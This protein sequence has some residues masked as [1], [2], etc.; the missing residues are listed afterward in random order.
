MSQVCE[1]CQKRPRVGQT[2]SH[3]NI[4]T[5]RWQKINLQTKRIQGKKVL[6]CSRCL[7]ALE[8]KK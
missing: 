5:K 4:A 6:L 7:K 8:K 1:M 2:R 3:S